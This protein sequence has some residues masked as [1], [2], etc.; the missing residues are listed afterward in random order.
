MVFYLRYEI[1][2]KRVNPVYKVL[3]AEGME[4]L[5]L[6]LYDAL[7]EKY[8]VAACAD[9]Q[10]AI[11]LL[12][13][14]T[15]DILILDLS[16]P[17]M[18]GLTV[19]ETISPNIPPVI[20][21]TAKAVPIYAQLAAT[22]LGVGY[23]I[24]KPCR[25]QAA[26]S[27]LYDMIKKWEHPVP[28]I[29]NPQANIAVHLQRLSIP[30]HYDGYQQLRV[31]IPLFAQDPVQR[32]SKELYP[33]IAELCNCDNGT[34]VEHTIRTAIDTAWEIRDKAVWEYYFPSATKSPSNKVFIARLAE[35]LRKTQFSE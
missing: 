18:D 11:E 19:L 12:R 14:S 8:E 3:I 20:L 26:L 27:R 25:T 24:L 23:I 21:C 32:L 35:E 34:Q 2:R 16:L 13:I 15:P 7:R 9:G 29:D 30:R 33:S 28:F 1:C 6:Q 10:T 22:E 5:R 31:G 4:D 17:V